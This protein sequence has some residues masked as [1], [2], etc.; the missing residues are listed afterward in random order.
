MPDSCAMCGGDLQRVTL[1]Q[2]PNGE[3]LCL[4]CNPVRGQCPF[5]KEALRSKLARQCPHCGRA[6]HQTQAERDQTQR[7]ISLTP[8]FE[9]PESS[10][11]PSAQ[12]NL[13]GAQQKGCGCATWAPGFGLTTAGILWLAFGGGILPLIA[14]ALFGVPICTVLWAGLLATVDYVFAAMSAPAEDLPMK[15]LGQK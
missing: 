14:F 7:Q 15:K 11:Q 10:H 3:V 4:V 8:P 5:C 6:W 2:S 13:P 9:T 1:R 12:S